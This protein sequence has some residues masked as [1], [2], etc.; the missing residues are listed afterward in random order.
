MPLMGDELAAGRSIR[1]IIV[2]DAFNREALGIESEFSLQSVRV[3]CTLKR[4]I[5]RSGKRLVIR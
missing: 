2:I 5:R 1:V 4:L 3:I